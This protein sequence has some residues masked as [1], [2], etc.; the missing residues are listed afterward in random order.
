MRARLRVE[1][2][3]DRN[4]EVFEHGAQ[5]GVMAAI[6]PRPGERWCRQPEWDDLADHLA[7]GADVLAMA[8]GLASPG[9]TLDETSSWLE[10][11]DRA[12]RLL[13]AETVT[14]DRGISGTKW[15]SDSRTSEDSES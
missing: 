10:L 6:G 1:A 7:Q 5:G 13:G 9:A 2:Y 8:R 11:A 3:R 14:L 4:P 15:S 12:G